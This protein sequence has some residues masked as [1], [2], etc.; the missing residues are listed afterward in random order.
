MKYIVEIE[1]DTDALREARGD[2]DDDSVIEALE[3]EFGWLAES[4]ITVVSIDEKHDV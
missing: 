1:V 3:A 4:G 2:T